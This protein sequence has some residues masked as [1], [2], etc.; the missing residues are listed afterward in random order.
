LGQS[1]AKKRRC[2]WQASNEDHVVSSPATMH[3]VP[4]PCPYDKH[5]HGQTNELTYLS[6]GCCR[7]LLAEAIAA[8]VCKRLLK[9]NERHTVTCAFKAILNVDSVFGLRTCPLV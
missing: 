7:L 6:C 3:V 1:E 2:F 9:Q 4:S 5:C 8:A